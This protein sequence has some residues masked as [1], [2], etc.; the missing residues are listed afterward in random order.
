MI[1]FRA[2]SCH[3][4]GEAIGS[5]FRNKNPFAEESFDET[6]PEPDNAI[7]GKPSAVL[8]AYYAAGGQGV[9]RDDM[10]PAMAE[11]LGVDPRQPL[12]DEQLGKLYEG[13]RADTGEHWPSRGPREI[14]AYDFVFHPHKSVSLAIEFAESPA[15]AAAIRAAVADANDDVMRYIAH[16]IGFARRGKNGQEGADPG[17]TTW[18]SFRHHEARPTVHVKDGVAGKTESFEAPVPGDPHEHVHNSL[19]NLVRTDDG[20]I[21]SLDTQRLRSRVHEFGAFGQASLGVKLRKIGV[22]TAYDEKQQAVVIPSI[23]QKAVDA[24]SKSHKQILRATKAYA[25][26]RGL[27]WEAL[28]GQQKLKIMAAAARAARLPKHKDPNQRERWREDAEAIGW[29]HTTVL[30]NHFP[31]PLTDE[32]RFD[33]AYAFAAAQLATEFR[34]AAVIDHDKLRTYAARGLIGA[35]VAS[36]SDIDRVVDLIE[37]RGLVLDGENASVIQAVTKKSGRHKDTEKVLRVTTSAHLKMEHDLVGHIR[38][39]AASKSAALTKAQIGAAIAASGLDF[40]SDPEHGAAQIAAIHA[41]GSG[42]GATLL[43]GVAGSGKTTLLRPLVAAWQGDRRLHSAGREIIGVSTAWRQAAALRDAGI[44]NTVALDP[45]LKSVADGEVE[46]NRNTVLVIDEASQIGVKSMLDIFRLQEKTGMTIVALGDRE[47]AQAIEAGDTIELMRRALPRAARP[48]ILTTVRQN[49]RRDRLIASLF[50]KEEA[51]RALEMKR[52]D[53][54]AKLVGGDYDQVVGEIADFYLRRRDALRAEDPKKTISIS[55]PTNED[56]MEISRAV[57][58][59][60]KKRGELGDDEAVYEAIAP[61]GDG[62]SIHFNLPVATGDRVRLHKLT[63]AKIGDQYGA[64][65]H[66]GDVVEVAGRT[67]RHIYLKDAKGR[68]GEVEWRRVIHEETGRLLL[69][70]GHSLTIDSAQGITSDE[71]INALPRGSA[72]ITGFKAYVAESRARGSTWTM[73]AEGAVHEAVRARR[74]LGDK[75]SV[76]DD[77]LW[78]RIAEDMSHKP[79]KGLAIDL[80]AAARNAKRGAF[81]SFLQQGHLIHQWAKNG[82]SDAIA[83]S[84]RATAQANRFKAQVA[85]YL[86]EL[87]KAIEQ[88]G[89]LLRNAIKSLQEFT[90]AQ[91]RRRQAAAA[92]RPEPPSPGPRF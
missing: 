91:R 86:A 35:G 21:G 14:S 2:I 22:K 15:E 41:I 77:D 67:A 78:R 73:V 53:G 74:P 12:A 20:R 19:F 68:I 92:S 47:Q 46:T 4:D 54:T 45:F 79:Y 87:T 9:W 29:K 63:W 42:G 44:E 72:G 66:N 16:E 48:E 71:H 30:E 49:R 60:L 17:E 13:R 32:Q 89:E 33:Q 28:P 84:A 7:A 18:I 1:S 38:R 27:D 83:K 51:A 3:C 88:N 55:A 11:S 36:A 43:T 52:D 62:K 85:P 8:A 39:A 23:P 24:F 6:K 31:A 81:A 59:K 64:I 5:Y 69:G 61:R 57:R 10:S 34:N 50:R 26:S 40:S 65:G 80:A 37:E 58:E 90:E 25:K 76:N 75:R 56:A 70:F 82:E